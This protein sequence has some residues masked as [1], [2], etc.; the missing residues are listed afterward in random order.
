MVM[1]GW[2]MSFAQ[3]AQGAAS[4]VHF[5][6]PKHFA[7]QLEVDKARTASVDVSLLTSLSP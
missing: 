3:K 2:T 4:S 7:G 5:G 6:P 1:Q